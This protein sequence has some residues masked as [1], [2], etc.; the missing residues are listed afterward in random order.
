MDW[1]LLENLGLTKNEAKIYLVLVRIG[2]A[3]VNEIAKKVD[4]HRVNIYDVLESLQKKGLISSII[5]TNKRYF[6]AASPELLKKKLEEKEKEIQETKNLLPNLINSYNSSKKQE[7]H[8]FKGV[9]GLKTVLKDILNI[10]PDEIL[11]FGATKGLPFF[12]PTYFKIWDSQ[13]IKF[14]IH[15]KI[16]TS[17]KIKKTIP[18]KKLQEIRYLEKQFDNFSST[19]IYENK[20]AIF[21][22]TEDPFAILIE[23]KE[24]SDSYKNYF[25]SL[26]KIAKE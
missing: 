12:L 7:I 25:Y 5:K 8:I 2:S 3:S 23:S 16:I 10:K 18:K 15:L 24:I 6:E 11:D 22:W 26:W 13:R 20:M 9:L 14:K 21:M 1:K 4:V 19:L 17:E